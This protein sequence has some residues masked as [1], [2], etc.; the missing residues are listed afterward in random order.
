MKDTMKKIKQLLNKIQPLPWHFQGNTPFDVQVKKPRESLS[1]HTERNPNSW[2]YD[3]GEY[4]ALCVNEMP[5]L[6]KYVEDL[7]KELAYYVDQY[8]KQPCTND[9]CI[10]H[11]CDHE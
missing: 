2:H 4:L 1:K 3:D 9:R 7:E 10:T 5:N 8:N 11:G 6:L